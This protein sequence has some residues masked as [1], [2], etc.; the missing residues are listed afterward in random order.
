MSEYR[1]LHRSFW[2]SGSV[3]AMDP[4][5]K[6]LYCYL[7]TSPLSNM[8][9]LYKT[10]LRRIAFET[11]IDRDMCVTLFSR[12]ELKHLAGFKD[13]WACVTQASRHIPASNKT[14]MI[15]ADRLYAEIPADVM[16]WAKSIGYACAGAI[17]DPT[18][19]QH[20]LDKTRQDKTTLDRD[21]ECEQNETVDV[22]TKPDEVVHAYRVE[23]E[24][25]LPTTAWVNVRKQFDALRELAEKT[26]TIA[27]TTPIADPIAFAVAVC[28]AFAK[29]KATG[30]GEYW[31][32]VSW[33]PARVLQRFPELVTELASQYERA[34]EDDGK[35][36]IVEL[37][38]AMR[39][40]S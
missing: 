6:L 11:G 29:K 25:H 39:A 7:I 21:G 5:E 16:E 28:G 4:V 34:K 2:E 26:R 19:G 37:R 8:E 23:I 13:G 18:M 9:G 3:E 30:R 40:K 17:H 27:P 15:H 36:G 33:E 20:I 35:L 31:R 1:Q 12:L 38:E 24:K 10:T 22:P 32:G 14:L